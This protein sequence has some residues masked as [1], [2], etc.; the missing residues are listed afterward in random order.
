VKPRDI[1]SASEKRSGPKRFRW[2][3]L[4]MPSALLLVEAPFF[5]LSGYIFL[6]LIDL[7]ADAPHAAVHRF[8]VGGFGAHILFWLTCLLYLQRPI[9]R[10]FRG[11]RKF[12]RDHVGSALKSAYRMPTRF[13]L[14]IGFSW[15]FPFIPV[16]IYLDLQA[17]AYPAMPP[18]ILLAA[19]T[20]AVTI[21]IGATVSLHALVVWLLAPVT[22]NLSLAALHGKVD[23]AWKGSSLTLRLLVITLV[24]SVAPAVFLG[25]GFLMNEVHDHISERQQRAEWMVESALGEPGIAPILLREAHETT[26]VFFLNPAAPE[27]PRDLFG[28][29]KLPSSLSVD[30]FVAQVRRTDDGAIWHTPL[31][32]A[33]A[34]SKVDT[35]EG[36]RVLVA[37]ITESVLLKKSTVHIIILMTF[38]IL[39]WGACTGLFISQAVGGGT[40]RIGQLADSIAGQNDLQI[41][42]RVPILNQ[43]EI[44]AV[45]ASLN[46]MIGRLSHSGRQLEK[47]SLERLQ[48]LEEMSRRR[49]L[50]QSVLDTMIEGVLVADQAG[51][52]HL[53]NHSAVRIFGG[54][55][56]EP[57]FWLD[58]FE[59][60]FRAVDGK[61][62]PVKRLPLTRALEGEAITEE[63]QQLADRKPP[64]DLRTSAA[65]IRDAR[66][67]VTGAITV[68]RDVT[69]LTALDRLK[70]EFIR[71]SAH[72]L[73]TPVTVV[74]GYVEALQRSVGHTLP[75]SQQ[76]L[77]NGIGQGSVRLSR[78]AE[79]LIDVAN[80]SLGEIQIIRTHFD[81][82]SLVHEIADAAR[83]M[84]PTHAIALEGPEKCRLIADAYRMRQIVE[85][86]VENAVK[87]SPAGSEVRLLITCAPNQ[88]RLKVSDQGI[89]IPAEKQGRIFQTFYRAHAD[90]A[91]DHGGL[92]AS[93]Y[94]AR[95]ALRFMGGT[96]QFR[97]EP[98]VGSTFEI[99]IPRHISD[100]VVPHEKLRTQKGLPPDGGNPL[101][102]SFE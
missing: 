4:R 37:A 34:W 101:N 12:K 83:E 33:L 40:R 77:L 99:T 6:R 54:R 7:P 27:F 31:G 9:G 85:T 69:E 65:P 67:R 58:T 100:A 56:P 48:L 59:G 55:L 47:A 15:T 39:L 94:L 62:V 64:V 51:R 11:S 35:P 61:I 28:Q 79:K 52:I 74:R 22:E 18:G 97:S 84:S 30:Q 93:L 21:A 24:L 76:M 41:A 87:F 44:G 3:T 20:F 42:E 73:K 102:T 70:D 75:P 72:E 98:G 95:E 90:T 14:L 81:F 80:F 8:L 45:A 96:I 91:F 16:G 50:L 92:G 32:A 23:V 89:G 5:F 1:D 26:A 13:G 17:Q 82:C 49:A 19:L 66:S 63:L 57:P 88:A 86:L 25:I 71:T 68:M 36:P 10:W 2:R 29:S 38:L 43:D 60:R 53:V 46:Q 78:L